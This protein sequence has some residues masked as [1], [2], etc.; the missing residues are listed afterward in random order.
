[1][2]SDHGTAELLPSIAMDT[3]ATAP[4]PDTPAHPAPL[5]P[6]TPPAAAGGAGEAGRLAAAAPPA[7]ARPPRLHRAAVVVGIIGALAAV[8]G[9]I[10]ALTYRS[11]TDCRASAARQGAARTVGAQR[12]AVGQQPLSRRFDERAFRCIETTAPAGVLVAARD[13]GEPVVWFVDSTG[14]PHNVNLLAQAW[15][16]GLSAA[17]VLAP[18]VIARLAR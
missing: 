9:G 2:H 14:V 17:P 10:F 12:D 7:P 18:A 16:P 3:P 4:Q 11:P 1:M 5:D 15:T 6:W 8:G 13:G